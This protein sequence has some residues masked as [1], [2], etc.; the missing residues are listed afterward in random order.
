LIIL[1]SISE[2]LLSLW[3]VGRASICASAALDAFVSV[4]NANAVSLG[5][6]LYRAFTFTNSAVD[7]LFANFVSHNNFLLIKDILSN[8][9]CEPNFSAQLLV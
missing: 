5:D 3:S 2:K 8:D 9:H 1:I 4:D 7:A 6:S